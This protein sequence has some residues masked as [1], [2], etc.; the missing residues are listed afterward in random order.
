MGGLPR[1]VKRLSDLLPGPSGTA[2]ILDLKRFEPVR[3]L[4]QCPYG[5]ESGRGIAT[6][7]RRGEI[8]IIAHA[9]NLD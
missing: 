9:V 2:R 1:D 7:G 3:Q 6:G 5:T 8:R 4:A